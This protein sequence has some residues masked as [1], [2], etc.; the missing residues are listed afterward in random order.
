MGE[1]GRAV[2]GAIVFVVLVFAV[3]AA[4]SLATGRSVEGWYDQLAKPSWTP[5][6]WLF[7]PV[8]TVL[9]LMMAAAAWAVWWRK[10]LR[11]ARLPLG[12]WLGQLLLNGAWS[13]IFFGLHQPGWALA[14][15]VVLWG[16]ILATLVAFWRVVPVAG[17][18]MLPYQ[19]WVT[20]A[21]ALNFAIWRLNA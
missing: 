12:L 16:A 3:A 11:G 10:G 2:S 17:W 21:G 8:W 20:F 1:K 6:G 9:Y 13:V 4:G 15:L 5:P 18:L 14:E 7:G 19:L